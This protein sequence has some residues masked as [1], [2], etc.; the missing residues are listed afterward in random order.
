MHY[1]L[2][3][4]AKIHRALLTMG[5]EDD[6]LQSDANGSAKV[7]LLLMDRLQDAWKALADGPI[8]SDAE[9][10]LADLSWL[11]AEVRRVRPRAE[12][13]VRPG[14]DEPGAVKVLEAFD[15]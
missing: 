5:D 13:F 7:A 12:L 6:D 9:P 11:S 3:L 8:G 10:F 14:F 4:G 15:W 1:S 2:L